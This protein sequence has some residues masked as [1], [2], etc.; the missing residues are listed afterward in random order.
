MYTMIECILLL[1]IFILAISDNC[2]DSYY[3]YNALK[4]EFKIIAPIS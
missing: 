3:I 4:I 2:F 1:R